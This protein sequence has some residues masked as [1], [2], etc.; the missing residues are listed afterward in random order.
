MKEL[1]ILTR[2]IELKH[3]ELSDTDSALI[4]KAIDATYTAYAP[5][6]HFS[7]GAAILLDNGEIISGSNQENAA[8]PSG[9]CAERTAAFW[10][11]SNYPDATFITIAVAARDSGGNLLKDPIS[12]CGA[13]RQVLLEFEKLSAH[14]V[15]VILVGSEIC[16]LLPSVR[17]L[18]PLAF[19]EF[20]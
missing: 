2:I 10:A 13:C 11:H 14:D 4:H 1:K 17:S 5:Y 15:R 20:E 6:S 12:P 3:N 8:T 18:L 7:V 16:Y 9:L 19:T